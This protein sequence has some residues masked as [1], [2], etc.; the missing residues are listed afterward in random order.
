MVCENLYFDKARNLDGYNIRAVI[1]QNEKVIV[2]YKNRIGCDRCNSPFC[3]IL[4]TLLRSI[5][6]NLTVKNSYGPAFI[7][8]D[9]KPIGELKDVFSGTVDVTL[10]GYFLRDYWKQQ[11][12]AFHFETIKIASLRHFTSHEDTILFILLLKLWFFLILSYTVCAVILKYFLKLS[13]SGA[14]L[15]LLRLLINP[16]DIER[17]QNLSGKIVLP[18]VAFYIFMMCSF[19][20]SWFSTIST[21]GY[22]DPAIDSADDLMRSKLNA[23]TR[24]SWKGLFARE[25]IRDRILVDSYFGECHERLL[26]GDHIACMYTEFN[27]KS[28]FNQSK[29]IHISTGNL[30]ERS[31]TYV[32][33]E[34]FPL[35]S[36]FNLILLKLG[37]GGFIKIIFKR[38]VSL[39]EIA[40]VSQTL[41]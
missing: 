24:P 39:H 12:Y 1:T 30:V 29:H 25:D 33:A 21:V 15:T 6:A 18:T 14:A 5:N 8:V 35:I 34:D 26:K 3:M 37:E 17:P 31:T 9:G 22:R 16:G 41:A 20:P 19:I 38:F 27:L 36:K 13:M 7:D 40:E 11:T 4:C 2:Y 10:D 23:Y 32:C 28:I